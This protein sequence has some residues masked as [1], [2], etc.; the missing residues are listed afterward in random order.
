MTFLRLL[1]V[2]LLLS[3]APVLAEPPP[4]PL[5]EASRPTSVDPELWRM[6]WSKVTGK[7]LPDAVRQHGSSF[8]IDSVA[9]LQRAGQASYQCLLA[10]LLY[11]AL[12]TMADESMKLGAVSTAA[13]LTVGAAQ[14]ADY[15]KK[16]CTPGDGDSAPNAGLA[17]LV[18]GSASSGAVKQKT[19]RA[20]AEWVAAM[21][22][23]PL[24][25]AEVAAILGAALLSA[26]VL[27]PL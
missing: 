16:W 27:A 3:S 5:T 20:L 9:E 2:A 6:A 24:T 12:R 23:R 18:M 15:I 26:P 8:G 22:A 19:G 11:G 13:N 17:I 25:P 10:G 14:I 21:R 7:L 4:V 1:P